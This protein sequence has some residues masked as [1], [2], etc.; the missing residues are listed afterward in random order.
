MNICAFREERGWSD[1]VETVVGKLFAILL[2]RF[3]RKSDANAVLI[4][5]RSRDRIVERTITIPHNFGGEARRLT[6]V[7]AYLSSAF[8]LSLSLS[9]W[10][11]LKRVERLAGTVD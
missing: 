5:E 3:E 6:Q 2:A 9:R 1:V 7:L 11:A 10:S 8:F 4:C